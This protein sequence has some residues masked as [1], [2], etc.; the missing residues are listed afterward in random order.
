MDKY[1]KNNLLLGFSY[2]FSDG[3]T[4]YKNNL[5]QDDSIHNIYLY[6]MYN[7]NNAYLS[8][9]FN[10]GFS[11][12]KNIDNFSASN[13]GTV[14]NMGYK[15]PQNIIAETGLR[16]LNLLP[17]SYKDS[18]G[19]ETSFDSNNFLTWTTGLK[20]T[21][22][23]NPFSIKINFN[24]LYD[25]LYDNDEITVYYYAHDIFANTSFKSWNPFGIE[26]GLSVQ[27]TLDDGIS[28]SIGYLLS[29]RK[30]FLSQT[31]FLHAKYKF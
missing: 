22:N 20:Y 23:L 7:F 28:L 25:I 14:I 6:S 16:Y 21:L 2:S 30:D 4:T 11:Q 17:V 8:L 24:I 12:Y 19:N 26:T 9:L 13:F 3:E 1:I 18:I 27:T 5:T 15:T 29:A 31:A 10:Y